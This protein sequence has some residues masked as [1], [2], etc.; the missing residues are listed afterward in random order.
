ML[1]LREDHAEYI[2]QKKAEAQEALSVMER[3]TAQK[4]ASEKEKHGL[5]ILS[6]HYGRADAFTDR[7]LKEHSSSTLP[8]GHTEEAY[9]DVTIPIQALVSDSKLVIPSGRAKYNLLGFWDPCIGE[10]KKL[11]VRYI[12]KDVLHQVTVDD[13][14]ALRAPIKGEYEI[15]SPDAGADSQDTL[16]IEENLAYLHTSPAS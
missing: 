16:C 11:R 5:V 13:V 10:P 6:A 9:I 3:P 12:F 2:A 1:E 4:A 7:G 8:N 14:G 15:R